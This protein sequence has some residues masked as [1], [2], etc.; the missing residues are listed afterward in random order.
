[1]LTGAIPDQRNV[2]HVRAIRK[3]NSTTFRSLFL[4]IIICSSDF[5]R[6]MFM[7]VIEVTFTKTARIVVSGAV[8]NVTIT[9]ECME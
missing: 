8:R 2:G 7:Q 4:I 1:M 6:V 3:F 5:L 9:K